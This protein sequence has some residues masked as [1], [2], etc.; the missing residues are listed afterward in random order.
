MQ[1]LARGKELP[2]TRNFHP[3]TTG[4]LVLQLL[5]ILAC[6]KNSVTRLFET[7]PALELKK[8]RAGGGGGDRGPQKP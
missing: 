6:F 2:G 1:V 5:W 3:L 7:E 4:D 8:E